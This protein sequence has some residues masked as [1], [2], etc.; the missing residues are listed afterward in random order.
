MQLVFSSNKEFVLNKLE[1]EALWQVHCEKIQFSFKMI[2]G[3][4]FKE[5]TIDSIVGDYESN[6]AGNALNEPMLFRFSVRHKLGTIFHELAHR[7]LL[8]YQFQY[9]G[10]LENN[11]EL[12]DLFLYDVIQESFG[13]SAARERVNYECT[14]PGLE[15]PDAWNKILEHSR[16]KRQELWKA[17]LK[18]TPISQCIN[19]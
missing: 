2:T 7:L 16:S 6:F 8:E 12:I 10:I 18:N 14:F 1:Y 13:E 15:I 11:H 9:G 19:N 17:V 5:D 4:S 3:L